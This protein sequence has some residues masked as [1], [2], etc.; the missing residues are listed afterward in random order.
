MCYNARVS[1]G[2]FLFVAAVS[3]YLW[4]RNKGIDRT[5]ALMLIT[6]ALMQL[7]EWGLW[8]SVPGCGIIN[9]VITAIIPLYLVLQPVALNLI[10]GQT[11]AGWAGG[12]GIVAAIAAALMVPAELV[13]S[14]R[15]FGDCS[16]VGGPDGDNLVW[17]HVFS[18]KIAWLVYYPAMIYPF[19]TLRNPP[20]SILYL[21]FAG[22]SNKMFQA[23]KGAAWPSL[24][25]Q[26]VNIL[27]A[28][29]VVRP[30]L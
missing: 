24:W 25:C 30:G 6:I 28:F 20:F 18:S 21:L 19:A 2:T 23:Q 7:L 26:F 5:L 27:A 10:V 13:Y 15:N 14:V 16:Y 3:I 11:G 29:A 12:Y 22:L 1:A 8:L 4:L 9:K 17:K